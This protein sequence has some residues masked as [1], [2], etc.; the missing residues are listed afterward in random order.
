MKVTIVY[1]THGGATLECAEMLRD[2]LK[3]RFSVELINAREQDI[4]SAEGSN[5]MIFGSSVRM[6]GMN[7]KMKK[8]IKSNRDKLSD[9][10]C[11]VFFCC[12]YTKQFQE[13]V[14]TELPRNFKPSLGCHL[15]GGELKPDKLSGFDKLIVRFMRSGIKSQDFEEDDSDHHD[16]P[17]L[18]PEN[19]AL[20][21]KEICKVAK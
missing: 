18:I 4:P 6:G 14:E 3:E 12:G 17:E 20:L 16:L 19:I 21:A 2:Q 9:M 10:P 5:I 7:K 1:S 15:F 8:Y 13:Y 11:G